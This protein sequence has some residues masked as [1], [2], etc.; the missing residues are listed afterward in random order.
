ML[1]Y[2]AGGHFKK[3]RD[4]EKEEDMFATLIVQLPSKY[5]GGELVTYENN[6]DNGEKKETIFEFGKTSG[7]SAKL[8]RFF[9]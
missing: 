6:G 2:E 3:H 4:T 8:V 1:L 7:K 5:S 9:V